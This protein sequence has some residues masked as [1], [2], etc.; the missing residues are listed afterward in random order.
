[1][2]SF[3]LTQFCTL[4]SDEQWAWR[5]FFPRHCERVNQRAESNSYRDWV[6]C[7]MKKT[8]C[9]RCEIVHWVESELDN[10][11]VRDKT[12]NT[13]RGLLSYINVISV[14]E[15]GYVKDYDCFYAEWSL[16][17]QRKV[18]LDQ[19]FYVSS[20]RLCVYSP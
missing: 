3:Q 14:L 1:M 6:F 10:H 12:Q 9:K 18:D 7:C 15:K 13:P 16:F 5:C 19:Q 8:Y 17:S 20:N 11:T 2:A 4:T